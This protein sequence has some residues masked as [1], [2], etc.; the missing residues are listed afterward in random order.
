[1]HAN[2]W[3][4]PSLQ[5]NTKPNWFQSVHINVI[6]LRAKDFKS[7][8]VATHAERGEREI[9][10][11]SLIRCLKRRYNHAMREKVRLLVCFIHHFISIVHLS[12]Y[13]TGVKPFDDSTGN[14]GSALQFSNSINILRPNQHLTIELGNCILPGL[15]ITTPVSDQASRP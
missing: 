7:L 12:G 10:P 9:R 4:L 15:S 8:S 6:K 5:S 14:I 13:Y 3:C 11:C 1:M 2:L